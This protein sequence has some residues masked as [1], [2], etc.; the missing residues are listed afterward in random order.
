MKTIADH[1]CRPGTDPD[2]FWEGTP[3]QQRE[4]KRIQQEAM[5]KKMSVDRD[6]EKNT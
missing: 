2:G 3:E 4:E 1:W 6:S 5:D